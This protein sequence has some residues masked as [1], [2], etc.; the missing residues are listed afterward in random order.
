MSTKRGKKR[1]YPWERW[2]RSRKE[3]TLCKGVDYVCTSNSMIVMLRKWAR[4]YKRSI[5]TQIT[6][7]SFPEYSVEA[8]KFKTKPKEKRYTHA[9]NRRTKR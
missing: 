4:E 9:K 7:V 1:I 6:Y 2:V 5:T 3:V 8:V